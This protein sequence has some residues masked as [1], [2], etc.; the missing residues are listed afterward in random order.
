MNVTCMVIFKKLLLFLLRR[1]SLKQKCKEHILIENLIRCLMQREAAYRGEVACADTRVVR[2]H[3]GGRP[4]GGVPQGNPLQ[5]EDDWSQ[6]LPRVLILVKSKS[7]FGS[8]EA[9]VPDPYV[10]RPPGLVTSTDKNFL[11]KNYILI[12]KHIFKILKLLNFIY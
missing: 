1:I 10:F 4:V 7:T 9:S 12:V 8:I 11:A 5:V 6:T 2:L 3:G